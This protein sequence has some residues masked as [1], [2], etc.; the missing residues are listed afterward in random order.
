MCLFYDF[1][2]GINQLYKIYFLWYPVIGILTT[3]FVGFVASLAASM[4]TKTLVKLCKEIPLKHF[5]C[6]VNEINIKIKL[7]VLL[8]IKHNIFL[9]VVV[10]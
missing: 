10:Q 8:K 9:Y 7:F 1:R 6:S 2:Y 3:V 4:F 5:P